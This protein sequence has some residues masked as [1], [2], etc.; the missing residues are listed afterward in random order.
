MET[1]YEHGNLT[2]IILGALIGSIKASV[3][4]NKDKRCVARAIDI[5]LGVF[6]GVMLARHFHN[7]GSTALGGLL[8]LVGGVS[9]AV[10]VEVFMQ[11]LPS[12]AKKAIKNVVE[13]N[14]K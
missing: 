12:I 11:M 13:K 10:V 1:I 3:E 9:G 8:A 7:A 5:F 2:I 6:C 14:I 4:F